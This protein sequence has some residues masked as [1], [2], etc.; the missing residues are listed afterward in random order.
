MKLFALLLSF[1]LLLLIKLTACAEAEPS[2]TRISGEEAHRMMQR[3]DSF[4]LLDVRSYREFR[5]RRI[6]GAV[7]IP[8]KEIASR[9]VN[10]I[11]DKDI[12]ILVYCRSGSR[13]EM[14]A[15]ELITLG[16][17]NV[18]DFGGI[19]TDWPFETVSE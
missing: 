18:Y 5:E 7:L 4:I 9:A 6:E 1:G 3:A 12:L 15:K 2:Y 19:E 17:T 16:F 13:S 8:Q 10:E 11:P 14:A